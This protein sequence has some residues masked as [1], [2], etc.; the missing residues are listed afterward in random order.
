MTELNLKDTRL[1]FLELTD[2][3][4]DYIP[5]NNVKKMV[6]DL[7]IALIDMVEEMQEEINL[8]KELNYKSN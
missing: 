4:R 8:L 5:D 7:A 2:T 1:F 3:Y 6:E